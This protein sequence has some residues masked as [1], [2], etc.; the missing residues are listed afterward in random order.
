M[1]THFSKLKKLWLSLSM[2]IVSLFLKVETAFAAVTAPNNPAPAAG[3]TD[4]IVNPL[5]T[6]NGGSDP[7]AAASGA[8]FTRYFVYF[9]RVLIF[10]GMLTVLIIFI[11]GAFDWL[12][13]GGDKGKIDSARRKIID[14]T[15]GIIILAGSFAI[16][17]FI[18][19]VFGFD[20]LR[21]NITPIVPVP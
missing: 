15:I 12:T 13:A 10:F 5:L 18:G 7:A 2:G 20:L 19:K 17:Q 21:P 11:M 4:G 8:L 6:A 3:S 9:W 16:I 14:A 1:N